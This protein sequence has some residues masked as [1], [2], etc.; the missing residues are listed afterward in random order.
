ME[1]N[2]LCRRCLKILSVSEFYAHQKMA[3]GRLNFC[4]KCTK[5]RITN[6][7]EKNLERIR[8][9]DKIKHA[10]PESIA[11]RKEYQ[12]WYDVAKSDQKKANQSVNN[13]VRDRRLKK[14]PCV[15]CNNSKSEAHH[16]DYSKPLDVIW[17]CRVHH[18]RLHHNKFSLV[19]PFLSPV[20]T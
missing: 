12:K 14:Q 13:A 9:Y 19:P 8:E 18:M 5:I 6:H 1:T 4:K 16:H 15:I 7:R 10:R 11:R 2:K 3:D 20:M 17:L